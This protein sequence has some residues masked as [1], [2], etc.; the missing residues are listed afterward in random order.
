MVKNCLI[1]GKEYNA[2]RACEDNKD[3][4]FGWR[5]ICDTRECYQAYIAV[6]GFRDGKM[7]REKAQEILSELDIKEFVPC[8]EDI[9][10][11]IMKSNIETVS[12]KSKKQKNK[13]A[14]K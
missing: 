1:C 9:V 8:V 4:F 2:C 11:K 5:T 12:D 14:D 10:T 13:E 3:I 7:E 6:T